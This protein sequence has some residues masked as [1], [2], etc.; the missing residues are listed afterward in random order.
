MSNPQD[1]IGPTE[2]IGG[3][4]EIAIPQDLAGRMKAIR[5][6]IEEEQRANEVFLFDRAEAI[7]RELTKAGGLLY[8][9]EFHVE[10]LTALLTG[11]ARGVKT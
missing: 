8:T 2:P 6:W 3:A 7:R 11:E 10:S 1:A 9:T 4:V 5:W